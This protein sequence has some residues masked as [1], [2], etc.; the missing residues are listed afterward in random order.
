MIEQTCKILL[1]WISLSKNVKI[2]RCNAGQKRHLK[3][4]KNVQIGESIILL[5]TPS[6]IRLSGTVWQKCHLQAVGRL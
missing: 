5:N 2:I 3:K 6:E 4:D 1:E